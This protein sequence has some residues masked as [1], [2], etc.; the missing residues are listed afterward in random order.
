M[1]N[2]AQRKRQATPMRQASSLS[3]KPEFDKFLFTTICEEKSTTNLN[4]VSML[5]RLDLDPWQEAAALADL[6]RDAAARRLSSL[7]STLSVD[8]PLNED[9]VADRLVSLL[10]PKRS[11]LPDRDRNGA[12]KDI[13]GTKD[14]MLIFLVF[15]MLTTLSFATL[16]QEYSR[17]AH[18]HSASNSGAELPHVSPPQSAGR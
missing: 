8:S 17:S 9:A 2:V 14:R 16:W 10:P 4:V 11:A 5:A 1:N 6:P 13:G 3:F 18:S 7:L 15:Y 12:S